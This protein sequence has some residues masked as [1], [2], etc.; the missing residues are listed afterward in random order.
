MIGAP[1]VVLIWLVA[2]VTDLR[3]GLDSLAALVQNWLS[4]NPISGDVYFFRGRQGDKLKLLWYSGDGV[5]LLG[6]SKNWLCRLQ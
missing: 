1:A 6:T 3:K 2:G 5:C 4:G